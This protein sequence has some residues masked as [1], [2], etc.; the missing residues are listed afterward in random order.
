MSK[1]EG[2]TNKTKLI[3]SL[4]PS[5]NHAYHNIHFCSGRVGRKYTKEAQNWMDESINEIK[6]T[7]I[8]IHIINQDKPFIIVEFYIYWA[9]KRRRDSDNIMKLTLDAIKEGVGIDDSLFLP[10][11]ISIDID[12]TNPRLELIIYDKNDDNTF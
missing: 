7:N 5:V 8:N 2:M 1:Y 4:P 10:R 6:K 3:L 9:N 12:K 11:V